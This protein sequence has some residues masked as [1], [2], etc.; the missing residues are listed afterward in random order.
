MVYEAKKINNT[1]NA[2]KENKSYQ[3]QKTEKNSTSKIV[4]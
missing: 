3:K 4:N 2:R 1:K